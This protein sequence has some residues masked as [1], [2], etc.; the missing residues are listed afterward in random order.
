MNET[1]TTCRR[2][3]WAV[4]VMVLMA[5]NALLVLAVLHRE[6]QATV[7][8][9]VPGLDSERMI[10]P[11]APS[12]EFLR[13]FA[14]HYVVSQETYT[15]ST[16]ER[17]N[18]ALLA[19]V[20]PEFSGKAREFFDRRRESI[21]RGQVSAAVVL[22]DPASAAVQ[23]LDDKAWKVHVRGQRRT[24]MGSEFVAETRVGYEVVLEVGAPTAINPHGLYVAGAKPTAPER[25][26]SK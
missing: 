24:Y 9:L 5:L 25:V 14:V 11:N 4:L 1:Q 3:L 17:V 8:R 7:V 12:E 13:I 15:P 19:R 18:E 20:S 2:R 6:S 23:R 16:I 26:E 21:K 22:E 10:R